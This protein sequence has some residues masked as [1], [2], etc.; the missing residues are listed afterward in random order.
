MAGEP[1]DAEQWGQGRLL[2]TNLGIMGRG[3]S[4]ECHKVKRW[5]SSDKS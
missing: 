2:N 4:V 3:L 5:G 1:E